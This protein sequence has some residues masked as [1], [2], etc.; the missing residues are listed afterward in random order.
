MGK[1]KIVIPSFVLLIIAVILLFSSIVI[2]NVGEKGI[3]KSWGA[4]TGTVFDE[5]LH[6]KTPIADAVD[7]MDLKIQKYETEASAASQDLQVVQAKIAVNYRVVSDDESLIWIRQKIG[8]DYRQKII[9]PAIQEAVK[10]STAQFSVE[11]LIKKR[12]EVRERMNLVFQE[13]LNKVTQ[14]TLVVETFNIVNFDFS[15]E[16]NRAIELK[17]TAEQQA[18]KAERDLDRIKLEAQQKIETSKA[19]AEALRIQAASLL[20]NPD[21]LQLRWI[22]KWDGKLPT[23]LMGSDGGSNVLLSLPMNEASLGK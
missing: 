2:V 1:E 21:V 8:R 20:E 9:E 16:F 23:F 3:H 17:V 22:E 10:A 18:L 4:V 12:E 13:K 15:A 19:E 5:G 11:D 6:W 14:G 7:I